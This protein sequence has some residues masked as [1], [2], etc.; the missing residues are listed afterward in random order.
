MLVA[1]GG[2]NDPGVDGQFADPH[3]RVTCG[4]A[5]MDNVTNCEAACQ[6]PVPTMG[7]G[8]SVASSGSAMGR[9]DA[10]F[11]VNGMPGCCQI[12]VFA[13]GLQNTVRVFL[14]CSP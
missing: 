14:A 5:W 4:S 2:G 12:T 9:C 3:E 6:E 7:A 13:P 8:C 10:T 1:C 11:K